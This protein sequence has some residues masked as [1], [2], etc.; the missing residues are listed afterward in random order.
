M[1]MPQG[2]ALFFTLNMSRANPAKPLSRYTDLNRVKL[3]AGGK[4]YFDLLL[5]LIQQAHQS[6]HLQTYIFEQDQTG[7]MVA[8]ALKD[9][10]E[11][12][13][14]VFLL[15]DGYASQ[16]LSSSFTEELTRAGVH[17]RFFE[18]LLKSK[19][20]YFGRRLHHKVV[21]VDAL[22]AIVGGVN[23]SDH[24]N[25]LPG[26]PAWRDF[27]LFVEGQTALQLCILCWKTW[28]GFPRPM[29][30]T[31]CPTEPTEAKNLDPEHC[32]RV[33]MERNDWVRKINQVSKSYMEM[34]RR[35]K[36]QII[37]VS[38][39]FLPGQ[40]FRRRIAAASSRGVKVIVVL[41]GISDVPIAKQ[42]ER[43]MY[44]WLFRN[45]IEVYEYKPT[46]LHGKM[47]ICDASWM[48]TGSYNVNDISALASIEL[49]LNVY[50]EKFVQ[51]VKQ[52][53]EAMIAKD[54]Q[55]ITREDF[56]A[57]N[58]LLRRLWQKICYELVRVVFYLF[59][60]YFKQRE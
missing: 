43:H 19:S 10:A 46:V 50:D 59:T 55:R 41:A 23:I 49:N 24:Y 57:R 48:T 58:H 35:S 8:H 60:F 56:Q 44:G 4:P 18:P 53:I 45:H 32:S 17:F 34:F 38:S 52:T 7:L 20:Y 33:E 40:Q 12:G 22:R 51:T 28:R 30:S 37:I 29:G 15:V 26:K 21:V 54:C 36:S 9:A 31:P 27:A 42:A 16:N 14:E 3:I 6:V 5:E 39:Y 2:N 1:A 11:R 47:A 13:V 25:D